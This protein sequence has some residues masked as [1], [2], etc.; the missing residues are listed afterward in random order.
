MLERQ[1]PQIRDGTDDPPSQ[2]DPAA[3]HSANL[4]DPDDGAEGALARRAREQEAL[5]RFTDRLYRAGSLADSCDAALDAIFGTLECKAASILQFDGNGVMR[6]VAWRNLSDAYREAVDGHSP[7]TQGEPDPEPVFIAD[8]DQADLPDTLRQSIASEGIRA[9]AFIPLTC[10]GKACGKFMAYYDAPQDFN[11]RVVDLA[12]TIA[13]QL[14]FSIERAEMDAHRQ[15]TEEALRQSEERLR[16]VFDSP[17]IGVAVLTPDGRFIEVNDAF[18]ELCG[19]DAAELRMLNSLELTHPGDRAA[20]A[21]LLSSL[22]EGGRSDFVIEKRYLRKDGSVIWVQNSVSLTHDEAGRPLHLVKLIQNITERKV[23][24][25]RQRLLIDEINH[26]VKNTLATVQSFATQSLRNAATM[27]E[28]RAAFEARLIALSKSHDVLTRQH[29]EG[30]ELADVVAGAIT[31]Y[32]GGGEQGRFRIK[33]MPVRLRPKAV[34]ALSLAFH[35]LATNAVKYGALS[36]DTGRV[37]IDWRV[38][39][40]SR[41]FEL[42]WQESGGPMVEPPVRRGFGSRLVEQGLAQDVGGDVRL[43]FHDDGVICS[44]DAPLHEVAGDA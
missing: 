23:A 3:V 32:R 35:E 37:A 24:E 6:F 43:K 11:R 5:F 41:R 8:I 36:N 20:M 30:A 34:L 33:G 40:Q 38:D 28:G 29:W 15:V 31:P 4:I 19:Y 7:W 1:T 2:A 18:S 14:G 9:I 27:A 21:R 17:A 44:I 42:R 16:A 12:L 25:K 10:A 22:M 13:R 39:P 26:R